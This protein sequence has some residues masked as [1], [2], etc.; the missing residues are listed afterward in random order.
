MR[1]RRMKKLF[2]AFHLLAQPCGTTIKELAKQLETG[3][4]Q[5]YRVIE[6]MQDDFCFV[7]I[8]EQAMI[9]GE[10]RFYLREQDQVTNF[11]NMKVADLN[12]SLTEVI[13]LYFLK[14]HA[15][16]YQGT[17]IET[18][19]NRAYAKLDTFVPD[20]FGK[21]LEKVKTLFIPAS[22]FA[23]D[24]TGKEIIIDDLTESM[25]QN[26]TCLVEYHSFGDDKIKNFKVD[27]L[28]FFEQ[29]GGL[30]VFVRST[31]YGD[32]RILAVERIQKITMTDTSFTYPKEFDP[33]ALL[34]N[35]FGIFYDDPIAVKIRFPS[36]QA[37]YIEERRWAK[38]QKITKQEDGSI[39]LTMN[40]SGW[41]DVKRWILSFG[42]SAELLEPEEMRD[43][44]KEAA[45][46]MSELYN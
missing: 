37:R 15:R 39:V 32:I 1:G 28:N 10:I 44:L 16:I 29:N 45:L 9:G 26:K 18:E 2:D 43:Q 13:A 11:A 33:D 31:T 34:D 40:T 17:D 3:E 21:R 24:Y 20:G 36:N 4:R 30:Y 27:P 6:T 46:E 7:I 23:K 38:D 41:F 12:L 8:K 35:A 25:M 14:G 19:I 22:Q 5:A 42:P